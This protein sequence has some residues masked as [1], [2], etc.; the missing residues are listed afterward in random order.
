MINSGLR[1]IV[2]LIAVL[3]LVWFAGISQD[4]GRFA[5]AILLVLWI[6]WGMNNAS[7]IQ[8]L[9]SNLGA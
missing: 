8:T 1:L 3:A 4:T 6:L 2:S 5:V 7:R 9:A